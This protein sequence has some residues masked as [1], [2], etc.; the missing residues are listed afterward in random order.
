[1]LRACSFNP[2]QNDL[3]YR[4]ILIR[5]QIKLELVLINIFCCTCNRSIKLFVYTKES[6]ISL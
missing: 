3:P 6:L 4:K 5:T 1:M 2:N